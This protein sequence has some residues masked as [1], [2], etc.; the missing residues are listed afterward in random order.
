VPTTYPA[1]RPL[2]LIVTLHGAS[3]DARG[4]L[5]PL[6]GMAD[7]LGLLLLAPESRQATWD[8]L[9]GGY[10]PDVD[11][12]DRALTRTFDTYDVDPGRVM[13]GGFSDG[14]SY[15]LSLGITNGDVFAAVLAFSPGFSA[16]GR[17]RGSPRIF[18]SHG[19]RDA[20][21]PID[22]TSR[23]LAPRLRRDG[24]EVRYV[25]FEGGHAVPPEIARSA[26]TWVLE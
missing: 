3:G 20:V 14:A 8:V 12:I 26:L 23:K 6:G 21:L 4:G 22:S 2:P 19:K 15:A 18:M 11:F 25:E 1:R 7:E 17:A 16:A 13:V 5:A 10:G 24:H 9:L